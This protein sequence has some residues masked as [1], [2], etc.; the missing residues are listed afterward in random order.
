M[1]TIP[2]A[3]AIIG[4]AAE[5]VLKTIATTIVVT[6]IVVAI[7]IVVVI[8]QTVAT[9]QTMINLATIVGKNQNAVQ[10]SNAMAVV[11]AAAV[12]A[13]MAVA[14]MKNVVV[15]S[16]IQSWDRVTKDSNKSCSAPVIPASILTNTRIY[17]WKRRVRMFPHTSH[18]SMMCS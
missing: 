17:P 18:P 8:V 4:V 12:N 16:T 11:A 1:I 10:M 13:N 14:G 3:A 9:T 6:T 7:N 5:D 2:D 15:T